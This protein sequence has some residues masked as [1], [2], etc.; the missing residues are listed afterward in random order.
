MRIPTDKE[1]RDALG[2]WYWAFAA[3]GVVLG[4]A[5]A[6]VIIDLWLTTVR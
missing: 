1:C 5:L 6:Y 3:V 2:P 4:L